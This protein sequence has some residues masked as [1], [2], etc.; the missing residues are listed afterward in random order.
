MKFGVVSYKRPMREGSTHNLNLGDPIQAYAIRYLYE[1]MG[2]DNKD[3]IEISRYNAKSYDGDYTI[4][5]FSCFNMV[6]NQYMHNYD[7]LPPSP[8]IIPVY[9]SFHLHSRVLDEE[10]LTNLRAYQPIGCRDEETMINLRRHGIIAYLSGCVTAILPKRKVEPKKQKTFFVD[11]AKKV[12]EY[13]PKE[14]TECS[15][16]ITHMPSFERTSNE[17]YLT[18]DEFERFYNNGIN[19]LQRYKDEAT[20]VVT[21]RLHAAIPC[22]AMGIPVIL[23]SSNF[24]GRF[25][26][27]EKY[28][29]PY[30]INEIDKIDWNPKNVE[31]EKEK[32]TLTNMFIERIRF[33]YNQNKQIY[34]ISNF[35][36]K[37]EKIVYNTKIYNLIK[38]FENKYK[39]EKR[40]AL[41]GII[42][43]TLTTKNVIEDYF[44]N[45]KLESVIDQNITGTFEGFKIQRISDIDNKDKNLIFIVVPTAAHKYAIEYLENKGNPYILI[46]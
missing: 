37:R 2:I 36:E 5:P 42:P 31:Y 21:S 22:I 19:L 10:I 17:L 9:I 33:A 13:A 38:E 8:K 46:K 29:H 12:L 44:S 25:S 23:I 26:W 20:L 24:D 18:D 34:G 15:E 32:A 1:L 39:G 6:T 45:W 7:S 4:L 16:I 11:V 35:Y 27:V 28:I 3:I 43:S 41:W 30:T 14:I 40:Y